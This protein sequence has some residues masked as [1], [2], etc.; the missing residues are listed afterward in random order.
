MFQFRQVLQ[1]KQ[2]QY[3]A[4]CTP[5]DKD[6][7]I[8]TVRRRFDSGDCLQVVRALEKLAMTNKGGEAGATCSSSASGWPWNAWF[9]VANASFKNMLRK[10]KM[11]TDVLEGL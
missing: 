6:S 10:L 11:K 7:V 3:L 8:V 1:E 4:L 9:A 5:L 2:C